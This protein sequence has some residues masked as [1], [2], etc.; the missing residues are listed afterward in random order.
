MAASPRG[1]RRSDG[2]WCGGNV[3]QL[4]DHYTSIRL[5][6]GA[7]L[8]FANAGREL[9]CYFFVLMARRWLLS[10]LNRGTEAK[11]RDNNM[12]QFL[13]TTVAPV[14][15][16]FALAFVAMATPA[17]ASPH[18]F[19]RTDTSGM[20]NCGYSTLAQCR[21]A[22]SGIS[23]VCSR[24]PFFADTSTRAIPGNAYAYQPK[25][26]HAKSAVGPSKKPVESQ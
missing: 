16:L 3:F 12:K 26:L 20:L 18:E 25:S 6:R 9:R 17:A 2:P 11:D 21:A 13:K 24:D 7:L 19:C 22:S 4:N 8:S 1:C 5:W 10:H 15:A 23:G 14:T